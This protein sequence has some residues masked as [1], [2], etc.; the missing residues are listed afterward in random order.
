[1]VYELSEPKRTAKCKPP[2]GLQLAMFIMAF[3]GVVRGLWGSNLKIAVA[4]F[5]R[6]A[7]LAHSAERPNVA[8]L[9][10]VLIARR[11]GRTATSLRSN[12]SVTKVGFQVLPRQA[13]KQNNKWTAKPGCSSK[14]RFVHG[15]F[16]KG[17]FRGRC[18]CALSLKAF[19]W[20]QKRYHKETV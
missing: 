5:V 17:Q 7:T 9:V 14:C 12:L 16:L 11:H 8:P 19:H 13:I 10:A 20:G 18:S 1:M 6:K 3:V 2:P 4:T 15:N